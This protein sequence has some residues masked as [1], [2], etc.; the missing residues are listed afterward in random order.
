MKEFIISNP[1]TTE[2]LLTDEDSLIIIAC[3]GVRKDQARISNYAIDHDHRQ[4]IKK[5][6]LVFFF[7]SPALLL[8]PLQ[9]WDVLT[10]QQA[11]ELIE[12]IDDAQKAADVL[13]QAALEAMSTDNLSVIIIR[14][15]PSEKQQ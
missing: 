12:D 3:D 9:I 1:Y 5:N 14:L 8:L 15:K 2:T 13:L 7:F 6:L 4:T 11:V 10:D